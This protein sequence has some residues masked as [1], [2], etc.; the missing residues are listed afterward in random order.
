MTSTH[1]TTAS[2]TS[3]GLKVHF[4]PHRP[5]SPKRENSFKKLFIE[6]LPKNLAQ[7]FSSLPKHEWKILSQLH[8]THR[9][10]HEDEHCSVS[11]APSSPHKAAWSAQA[12]FVFRRTRC[13]S[14]SDCKSLVNF[15]GKIASDISRISATTKIQTVRNKHAWSTHRGLNFLLSFR[16]LEK[17]NCLAH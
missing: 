5:F 12:L 13:K 2:L 15:S 3:H 6:Q 10:A 14:L 17:L 11:S 8:E 16:I 9:V 1:N 4:P 7:A